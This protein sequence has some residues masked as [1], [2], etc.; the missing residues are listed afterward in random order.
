[1]PQTDLPPFFSRTTSG[2]LQIEDTSV[3]TIVDRFGSPT[4][5]YSR[6]A[7]ES[8]Y[9]ALD[10]AF[11]ERAHRICYAVKANSNIG[12]LS[13][14]ARLG[15][16]FDIVSYGELA[17]VQAAGGDPAKTVF[18][19]VGKSADEIRGALAAGIGCLNVESE[20]ELRRIAA[21]ASEMNRI[22]PISLRVNPDVD[23]RTHPYISTGLK[24]NKF[25]IAI[26]DALPLYEWA[27]AQ[28]S[29]DVTGID[30]HIGS[31]LTDVSPFRDAAERV[32]T[33]AHQLA[34]R[35]IELEH[36]DLGGGLGIRYIDETPPSA[37]DWIEAIRS[38]VD[39]DPLARDLPIWIEPGRFLVGPAGAMLTRVE[40]LKPGEH[41]SFAIVDAAMNDLMRPALYG[42]DMAIVSAG[43]GTG[44]RLARDWEIVG[45]V[46]ETGDFLG[47]DRALEL[48]EGDLLAVLG[49]GAYGFSMASNYNTRPRPAEVLVDGD[50]CHEI[51]RR[52][53]LES[54]WALERLPPGD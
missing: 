22:A 41:K 29:L 12:I 26:D 19:G 36:L 27:H 47:H 37:A 42:S 35:G 15:A 9:H 6:A 18:S 7:I 17:R 40:Y 51:R 3:G 23:A 28:P 11:G 25:G 2:E 8:A 43:T 30:C 50:T 46:C 45:P 21:I 5:A 20:A 48:A 34:E 14:L 4:Y 13:V 49:A 39:A 53:P 16:G 38:V 33:L 52:E 10:G 1:M 44:R 32:M 31:Q 24:D 54:L